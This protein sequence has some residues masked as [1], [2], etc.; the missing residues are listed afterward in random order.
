MTQGP[1]GALYGRRI[2]MVENGSWDATRAQLIMGDY[3]K[4]IVAIRKDISFKMFDQAVIS[5]DQGNVILNLMQQDA[6][7]MRMVMR[8]AYA[9]ANPVTTMQ[10]NQTIDGAGGTVMRFPFGI[11]AS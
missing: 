6:V 5:D 1:S 7:A 2:S 11:L 10:P 4:A 8:V 9:V 3:S